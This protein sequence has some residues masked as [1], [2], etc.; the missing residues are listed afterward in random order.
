MADPKYA[1][2]NFRQILHSGY[3]FVRSIE[4]NKAV[5]ALTMDHII[6]GHIDSLKKDSKRSSQLVDDGGKSLG[7]RISRWDQIDEI[8]KLF[9]KAVES[10]KAAG[11]NKTKLEALGLDPDK[12]AKGDFN[13]IAE[14]TGSTT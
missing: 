5:S 4:T 1:P 2:E 13:G 11:D 14:D 3:S 7:D 12:P 10:L 6:Q 8:E 9:T